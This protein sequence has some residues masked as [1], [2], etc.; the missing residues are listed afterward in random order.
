MNPKFNMQNTDELIGKSI[1]IDLVIH[2]YD[3]SFVE[4]KQMF[5]RVVRVSEGEGIVVKLSSSGH[6]YMLPPDIDDFRRLGPGE[7]QLQPD[8]ETIHDPDFGTSILV[9][10]P[11]PEYEGPIRNEVDPDPTGKTG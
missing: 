6:E 4:R 1:L 11:P 9:H 5:G 10:L 3:E 8:G 7:Y 2:D